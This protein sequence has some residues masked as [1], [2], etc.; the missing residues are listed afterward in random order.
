MLARLYPEL[1]QSSCWTF[2]KGG[3]D[4]AQNIY[5]PQKPCCYEMQSVCSYATMNYTKATMEDAKSQVNN[6]LTVFYCIYLVS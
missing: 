4:S 2:P 3:F 6:L 1:Q 5:P